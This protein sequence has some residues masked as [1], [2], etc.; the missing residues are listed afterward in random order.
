MFFILISTFLLYGY[1]RNRGL[2]DAYYKNNITPLMELENT[3][4]ND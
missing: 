4:N 1:I 2:L 3:D